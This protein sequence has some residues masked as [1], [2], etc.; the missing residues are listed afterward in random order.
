VNFCSC[1][2]RRK[3][4]LTDDQ[5]DKMLHDARVATLAKLRGSVRSI[6][7]RWFWAYSVEKLLLI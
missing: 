4:P 3:S 1:C 5:A 2:E 7:E 6:D